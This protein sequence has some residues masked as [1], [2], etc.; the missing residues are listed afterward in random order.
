MQNKHFFRQKDKKLNTKHFLILIFLNF[1]QGV[2]K[3]NAV[4]L[5]ANP[6]EMN[7]QFLTV[8]LVMSCAF[9]CS[10]KFDSASRYYYF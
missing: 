6:V 5:Q 9:A 3:Y 1:L 4:T 2:V 7:Q 8:K 10:Q